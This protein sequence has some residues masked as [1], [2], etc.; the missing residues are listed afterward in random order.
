MSLL[1]KVA[2]EAVLELSEAPLPEAPLTE[3]PLT[4]IKQ[5]V[6]KK[7]TADWR[8]GLLEPPRKEQVIKVM[9]SGIGICSKCRFKHGCLACCPE[10]ALRYHLGKQ[11][12]VGPAIW[13]C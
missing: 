10:K 13:H 9:A 2:A 12:Y 7:D 1:S 11:G 3:A 4:E 6:E 5:P 8:L